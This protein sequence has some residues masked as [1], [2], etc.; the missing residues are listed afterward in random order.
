[1]RF[2]AVGVDQETVDVININISR[3]EEWVMMSS[4]AVMRMNSATNSMDFDDELQR[5][6]SRQI[7]DHP[8]VKNRYD[9]ENENL[10]AHAK[11]IVPYPP[12][13]MP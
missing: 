7:G 5:K 10:L 12:F 11:S 3:I 1:M 4:D 13:I 2:D 9:L 6:R 8:V